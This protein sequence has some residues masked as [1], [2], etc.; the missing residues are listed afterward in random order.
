MLLVL[1]YVVP[2]GYS[3]ITIYPFVVLKKECQ[4]ADGV[5]INHE[6]IHLLQQ[7][8]MF[9]IFFYAWYVIEFLIRFVVYKNWRV[10]YRNISFEMESY[11]NEMNL[12]YI[13]KRPRWA[14]LKYV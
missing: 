3:G 4:K 12:G 10:A 1:K 6:Q 5:F 13:K 2:K 8:E 7:K 11:S 9:V 14:F